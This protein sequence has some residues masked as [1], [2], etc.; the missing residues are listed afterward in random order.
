MT[1][2]RFQNPL[3][4]TQTRPLPRSVAII[5]AGT[6]GPDIGYYLKSN[7]PDLE[8]ILVDVSEESLDKAMLRIA[9]YVDKGL[10]RRKLTQA[11]ATQVSQKLVPTLDYEAIT[12]CDWV[13][14]AAT[15]NLDLKRDIFSRVEGLVNADALITSNTSSLPAARLFGHLE[16]PERATV[17]HF[18]APAFLNPA[19][20]VIE[21][22]GADPET[23]EYLRWL[24]CATGKVPLVTADVVCFMLDRIFDNWCNE[25]GY[26]L[27]D[28]SAAQIDEVARELVHAGPFFVLNLANGNPI[29]IETNTLQME[30][31]GPHYRPAP[32]F[33]SVDRWVTGSSGLPALAPDVVEQVRDRLFGIL[34]SQSVDIMD[35]DIGTAA[36]L[37]LGCALALG[38]KKGPLRLMEELGEAEA[39]RILGR[40]AIERPGMPMPQ[41]PIGDYGGFRRH[42]L[43][44]ELD[45]VMVLTIRRPQALN[46]LDDEVNDELLDVI[47]THE[48]NPDVAGFVITGYGNRSFCAG[49]DIGRFTQMLG[50]ADEA[51]QYARDCSRLLVHLD[52]MSKP[53]VAAVNG[54]AL[55][56][57]LELA[58]RCHS[59]VAVSD[60]WFQ[61]PEVTL[62][63]APGIGA[64]VVP[65]R[66]WPESGAA[67]HDMVRLAE[68]VTAAD[69]AEMGFVEALAPDLE[70]LTAL[71]V[72]RVHDLAGKV[73]AIPDGPVE[74]PPFAAI[75]PSMLEDKGL[76][77]EVIDIMERAIR[78][79]AAATTLDEALEVGYEAFGA[80]ACTGA[81][82]DGI[83]AFVT[84]ST[85]G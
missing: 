42:V 12:H 26:L 62:G 30:E 21:W 4:D 85:K 38:F 14:E 49:A 25:A 31:E 7:I 83:T 24:F 1:V 37:E 9:G 23:I 15:E 80:T 20:E 16:H 58:F 5:G 8:L 70:S 69:A 76:D 40:L 66:R 78:A 81:A 43:V 27:D 17:T 54:M 29:I 77:R 48:A 73:S 50:Q 39:G 32:I 72:A 22:A 46:A 74:I 47:T 10:D 84:G 59:T 68:K 79:A 13:I 35:R 67:I 82:R 60:A 56:G 44:D 52:A 41:A 19:V 63:I 34:L 51:A 36:D 55:G 53:V 61:L 71:A 75:E 2:P 28:A 6:I 33:E 45:G 57:G 18:F 64:L 65:Y 3:L 11:Q